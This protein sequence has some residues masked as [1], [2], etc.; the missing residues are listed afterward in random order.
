MAARAD[1]R[2]R[3]DALDR[4]G[5][6]LAVLIS[7]SQPFVISSFYRSVFTRG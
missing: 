6:T 5:T 4:G 7:I 1:H 2:F 3:G